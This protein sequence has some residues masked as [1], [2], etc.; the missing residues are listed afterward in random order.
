MV[1]AQVIGTREY[2]PRVQIIVT[3]LI[4]WTQ[5]LKSPRLVPQWKDG[6]ILCFLEQVESS[7]LE[8]CHVHVAPTGRR[9]RKL[10]EKAWVSGYLEPQWLSDSWFWC[11]I[12]ARFPIS[13]SSLL[14][15]LTPLLINLQF[16][17]VMFCHLSL[18]QPAWSLTCA[19]RHADTRGFS[20][21]WRQHSGSSLSG[22]W[23]TLGGLKRASLSLLYKEIT[24]LMGIIQHER[25]YNHLRNHYYNHPLFSRSPLPSNSPVHLLTYWTSAWHFVTSSCDVSSSF[26]FPRLQAPARPFLGP[27]RNTICS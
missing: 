21:G 14:E 6:L 19:S 22:R 2:K 3:L 5:G 13:G 9:T 15:I 27:F 25:Y 4:V 26:Y 12:P 16:M 7:I 23:H 10:Q 1:Y 11:L 8:L 17:C 20:L 18:F 24:A